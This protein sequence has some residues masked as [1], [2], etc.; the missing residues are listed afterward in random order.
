MRV[1]GVS[2]NSD[3]GVQ[4]GG[5]L[6]QLFKS[7]TIKGRY[8]HLDISNVPLGSNY[9]SLI[10]NCI[11][12][13]DISTVIF[14]SPLLHELSQNDLSKLSNRSLLGMYV[15]D[16]PQYLTDW[17]RYYMLVMDFFVV[18][19]PA[20]LHDYKR[21]LFPVF[22]H[23]KVN[24]TMYKDDFRVEPLPS[25]RKNKAV[26]IG[27]LD[28]R[29]DRRDD[30]ES[31]KKIGVEYYGS[32]ID[33]NFLD[34]ENFYST[35]STYKIGIAYTRSGTLT[36]RGSDQL[37]SSARQ[38][39]GKIWDYMYSGLVVFSQDAPYLSDFFSNSEIVIFTDSQ[40][41]KKKIE[42][43]LDNQHELDAIFIKSQKIINKYS[44][45]DFSEKFKNFIYEVQMNKKKR[46]EYTFKMYDKRHCRTISQLCFPDIIRDT[47]Y[48]KSNLLKD[49][50]IYKFIN[51]GAMIYIVKFVR[52]GLKKW[53]IK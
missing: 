50:P 4:Q 41:L 39:K 6:S 44:T 14:Y 31:L 37:L 27:L 25:Q 48:S 18:A 1:L 24:M 28:H 33:L 38:L 53:I 8:H 40:D 2:K 22:W 12:K 16:N 7:S 3:S 47:L 19:E 49:V 46:P 34:Y 29:D 9:Y 43:Y 42:Y 5:N 45:K 10:S 30:L 51:Y 15:S 13:Y 20:E 52:N 17:F 32:G 35:L 11:D 36:P 21:Y 23:P 26:H